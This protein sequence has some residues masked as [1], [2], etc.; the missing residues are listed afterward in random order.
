MSE[1]VTISF[2]SKSDAAWF[3]R[4]CEIQREFPNER[5]LSGASLGIL[6]D[7]FSHMEKFESSLTREEAH[8]IRT[9]GI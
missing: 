6:Q 9:S 3:A 4:L 1:T 8:K 2:K 5:A 7:T